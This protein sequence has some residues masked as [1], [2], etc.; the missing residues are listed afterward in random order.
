MSV[1]HVI[2]PW[3]APRD[4]D[5]IL[6]AIR[7]EAA[8]SLFRL[9]GLRDWLLENVR[10]EASNDQ[11]ALLGAL[12]AYLQPRAV[13]VADPEGIERIQTVEV[14]WKQLREYGRMWGDCDDFTAFCCA[15]ATSLGLRCAPAAAMINGG[16]WHNHVLTKVFFQDGSAALWDLTNPPAGFYDNAATELSLIH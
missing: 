8:A 15:A 2:I 3:D 12:D 9:P 7:H 14:S 1:S 13:Y 6:R 11:R 4:I 10:P 5:A 16:K